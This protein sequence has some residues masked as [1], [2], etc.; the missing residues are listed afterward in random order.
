MATAVYPSYKTNE[1]SMTYPRDASFSSYLDANERDFV[2][3][4]A[5]SINSLSPSHDAPSPR[6]SMGRNRI[7]RNELDVFGAERYFNEKLDDKKSPIPRDQVGGGRNKMRHR[8]EKR[9][10]SWERKS[11]KSTT[12]CSL[13]S[14][15]PS[16]KSE[17]SLNSQFGLLLPKKAGVGL[18]ILSGFQ[19]KGSCFDK[20][21]VYT[22]T[23][24]QTPKYYQ[25]N[26]IN[27]HRKNRISHQE[28]FAFPI[29]DTASPQHY[30]KNKISV[31]QP[32]KSLDVFGLHQ[33]GKQD[34]EHNLERKLSI[35]AWDAIPSNSPN[36]ALPFPFPITKKGIPIDQRN[37]DDQ[38]VRSDSSSD[39][40]EIENLS[41][42]GKGSVISQTSDVSPMTYY[43]APSEASI[44]WSVVTASAVDFS[45]VSYD[46]DDEKSVI[47]SRKE[48]K[49][50]ANGNLLGC[51]NHK[52][53][54]VVGNNYHINNAYRRN[55]EKG[56]FDLKSN[57]DIAPSTPTRRSLAVGTT[58]KT[59][60]LAYV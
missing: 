60:A 35:L 51:R 23:T 25:G 11:S 38:D 27:G 18:K 55:I 7:P 29:I 44:E 6:V 19:C 21:S 34:I 22:T 1:G 36:T 43:D 46:R 13:R 49:N 24:H 4:L 47:K 39:L 53:V 57:P 37:D 32:R 3:N 5:E 56:K 9:D 16:L 20:K 8:R 50:S 14:P 28:H 42:I 52:A 31:N 59:Y 45:A 58:M 41:G 2:R 48:Q 26:N 17:G 40:F 12:T 10:D 15:S 33:L 54:D 30:R